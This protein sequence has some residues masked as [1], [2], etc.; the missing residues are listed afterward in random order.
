L[1]QTD[2][3]AQPGWLRVAV[4]DIAA[5]RAELVGEPKLHER[6]LSAGVKDEEIAAGSVVR[7]VIHCCDGP[8]PLNYGVAYVPPGLQVQRSDLVEIRVAPDPKGNGLDRLNV[9]TQIREVHDTEPSRCRWVP[10]EPGLWRRTIHC[11]WM[12]EEGWQE[13]RSWGLPILYTKQAP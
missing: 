2:V 10:P 1:I 8:E 6:L 5:T 7:V 3:D 13:V 12:T 4:V 9:V 11:D